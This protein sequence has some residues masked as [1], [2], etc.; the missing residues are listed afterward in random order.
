MHQAVHYSLV[1][2]R[3]YFLVLIVEYNS[4]KQATS[5]TVSFFNIDLAVFQLPRYTVHLIKQ[6]RLGKKDTLY[7]VLC[8]LIDS[9]CISYKGKHFSLF[10]VAF[11]HKIH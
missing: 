11:K 1:V 2:G 4:L 10:Y 3:K 6:N 7:S 9:I 8:D 5:L